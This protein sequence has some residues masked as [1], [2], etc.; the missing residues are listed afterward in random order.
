MGRNS[1]K[2]KDW[3]RNNPDKL[4]PRATPEAKAAKKA[5]KGNGTETDELS[6]LATFIKVFYN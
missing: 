5:K 3:V 1:Q 6:S 4:R 2:N